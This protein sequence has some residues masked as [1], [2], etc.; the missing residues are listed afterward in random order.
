MKYRIKPIIVDGKVKYKVQEKMFLFWRTSTIE[1]GWDW[2]EEA[3]FL[4]LEH[5]KIFKRRREI[6]NR[7]S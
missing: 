5:A 1:L 4:I 2:R 7:T 3:I 6:E